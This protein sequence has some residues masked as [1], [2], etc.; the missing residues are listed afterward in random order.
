MRKYNACVWWVLAA[1]LLASADVTD[2]QTQHVTMPAGKALGIEVTV[3][4][5]RIE[6]WDNDQAE[7]VVERRVPA[8]AQ[9]ARIPL[10]VEDTP[11][12]VIVRAVQI[13]KGTDRALRADVTV[14]LPRAALIDRVQILEGRLSIGNFSGS[15]TA[16]VRRGPIE[17]KDVSGSI[18]LSAE[19]GSVTLAGARLSEGGLLRVR[20]FNGD[21]RVSLAD[22]PTNARILALA[23]NGTLKSDIPLSRR[24][25]WGPRWGEATLGN[26][27]SVISL[28]VVRGTIEIKSP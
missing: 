18:R 19:I 14:K 1:A 27:D 20:T 21:V 2:T 11:S 24:E 22:R 16:D 25:T 3:G 12:R 10:S 13:D 7:I 9:F 6:G 23:M 5:V 4:N 15:I 28:D 17:G 26:G 8:T